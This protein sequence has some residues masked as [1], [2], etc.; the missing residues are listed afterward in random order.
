MHPSKRSS[1]KAISNIFHATN[2][3][4]DRHKTPCNLMETAQALLCSSFSKNVMNCVRAKWHEFA[5]NTLPMLHYM[6]FIL[7]SFF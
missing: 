3:S 6:K 1:H 2:A 5:R 7:Y 4:D